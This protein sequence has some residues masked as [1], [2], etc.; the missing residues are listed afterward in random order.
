MPDKS[1]TILSDTGVSPGPAG[2][3]SVDTNN[4]PAAVT[5]VTSW[6][7]GSAIRTSKS[8]FLFISAIMISSLN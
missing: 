8:P 7:S 5:F 4:L 1:P 2:G 6:V 3:V